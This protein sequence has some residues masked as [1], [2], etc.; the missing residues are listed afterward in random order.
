MKESDLMETICTILYFTFDGQREGIDMA[1]ESGLVQSVIIFFATQKL[2]MVLKPSLGSTYPQQGSQ[3]GQLS[4]LHQQ[5][6][7]I[8]KQQNMS[9]ATRQEN[10]QLQH[11]SAIFK[12]IF[13]SS[14][15]ERKQLCEYGILQIMVNM[16]HHTDLLVVSDILACIN[17]IIISMK[18][19]QATNDGLIILNQQNNLAR[20]ANQDD[21]D[22]D[23]AD[24]AANNQAS[25]GS[26]ATW[27]SIMMQS[28]KHPYRDVM[29][30]S[31]GMDK[32][33]DIYE[34]HD[35]AN[36]Q[37][38]SA[39]CLA[40]LL[41][42]DEIPL[43][44]KDLTRYMKSLLE[45]LMK[46]AEDR[47]KGAKK[48]PKSAKPADRKSTSA[49]K[50]EKPGGDDEDD[51]SQEKFTMMQVVASL[52]YISL[53]KGNHKELLRG[54]F[55]EQVAKLFTEQDE[56][57]LSAALWVIFELLVQ[58]APDTRRSVKEVFTD[59]GGDDGQGQNPKATIQRLSSHNNP[60]VANNAKLLYQQLQK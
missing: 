43:K 23:D 31:G 33:L 32:L 51:E 53:N 54:G 52:G 21:D 12:V 30:E 46:S 24:A 6:A 15:E 60:V 27:Q 59:Y 41:R 56:L 18:D 37:Q 4:Q 16:L 17:N 44:Y 50:I 14:N 9:V 11:S 35:T 45:K 29:E 40:F 42:T 1:H 10:Q 39:I 22:D 8:T 20:K 58:G 48:D 3:S 36:L 7:Q 57:I 13:L 34:K 19:D 38:T 26:N 2:Q 25:M 55:V 47:A 5:L 49:L 28:T